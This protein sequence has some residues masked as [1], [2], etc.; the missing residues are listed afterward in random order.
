MTPREQKGRRSM[1]TAI[2]N[3]CEVPDKKTLHAALAAQLDFPDW[4]GGNLDALYDLLSVSSLPCAVVIR[5]APALEAALGEYAR[6]L[7]R[8]LTDVCIA[9][10]A[11][12]LRIEGNG[13]T[14]I[15]TA[16]PSLGGYTQLQN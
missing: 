7:L 8:V 6:R 13:E 9:N 15:E 10:P 2:L 3:A 16:S 11:V 5:D 14:D 1:K 12:S 4:Y